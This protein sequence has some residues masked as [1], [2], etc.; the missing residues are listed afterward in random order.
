MFVEELCSG[1]L[2]FT[3]SENNIRNVFQMLRENNFNTFYRFIYW[4]EVQSLWPWEEAGCTTQTAASNQAVILSSTL[5]L[6]LIGG[7]VHLKKQFTHKNKCHGGAA[8]W[9][10]T[11]S[12]A[13]IWMSTTT[14]NTEDDSRLCWAVPECFWGQ[15][16]TFSSRVCR[17]R[18]RCSYRGLGTATA[19]VFAA[20]ETGSDFKLKHQTSVFFVLEPKNFVTSEQ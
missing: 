11:W 7:S 12:A 18:T 20:T 14:S 6:L 1:T 19:C 13:L 2:S 17:D 3:V 10:H 15:P 9:H 8:A 5:P 4:G 16:G